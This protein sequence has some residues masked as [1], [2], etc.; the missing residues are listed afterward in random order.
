MLRE[1]NVK[2]LLKSKEQWCNI[3]LRY[4][5]VDGLGTKPSMGILPLSKVSK[6][7]LSFHTKRVILKKS[8]VSERYRVYLDDKCIGAHLTLKQAL[9]IFNGNALEYL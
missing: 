5:G 6:W 4:V 2:E 9:D 1:S 7:G 3:A 8:T